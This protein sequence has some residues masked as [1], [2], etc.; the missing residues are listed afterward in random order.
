MEVNGLP[1]HALVTHG[2]VVFGPLAT[3]GGLAYAVPRFRD[4]VRWPLVV[5]VLLAAV[6]V[7]VSYVSGQSV[8]ENNAFL[9]TGE[10]HEMVETHEARAGVL[11]ISVT[12]LAVL[13]LVAAWLHTRTGAVRVALGVLV[14]GAAVLTGVYT[15]LT[16][17]A[18]AQIAW[19]GIEG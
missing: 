15:V 7:W 16:G 8:E 2:A 14:A 9:Q 1:L 12:A 5:T 17:D 18:G 4:R 10:V 13:T 11:R 19:S 3:L 6:S